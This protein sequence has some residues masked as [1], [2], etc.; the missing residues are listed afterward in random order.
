MDEENTMSRKE[1]ASVVRRA[2][3]IVWTAAEDYG[4]EPEFLSFWQD[5]E[6]DFYMNSIIGYAYKWYGSDEM[7]RFVESFNHSVH[8]DTW[9]SLVCP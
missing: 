8:R 3:N 1:N 9:T 2:K 5:G 4:Y 7:S 6:P